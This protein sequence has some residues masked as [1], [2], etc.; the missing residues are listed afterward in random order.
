MDKLAQ[1]SEQASNYYDFA[2]LDKLRSSTDK[3]ALEAAAKQF[4]SIFTKM[5]LTSMRKASEVLESDSPFNSQS[6]KFYRDMHDQQMVSNIANTGGLGLADMIMEQLAGTNEKFSPASVLRNDGG[7]PGQPNK[8]GSAMDV[9]VP[10]SKPLEIKSNQGQ[11]FDFGQRQSPF[12]LPAANY[13]A[14]PPSQ[15]AETHPANTAANTSTNTSTSKGE[16]TSGGI[17]EGI[18]SSKADKA[19]LFDSP[20]SFIESLL[21]HARKVA[22]AKGM[23]PLM[24]IAQAAL[25]TGWGKKVIKKSDGSSSHNLFGIKADS[26][27]QGDKAK[28]QTLEFKDGVAKKENAFF[29]A[30]NSVEESVKDYMNFVS[31]DD[32]YKEAM[33]NVKDP[34]KYFNALQSAG[35]ATDPNYANKVVNILNGKI[36]AKAVGNE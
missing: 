11:S 16:S 1:A 12:Q 36:F 6:T 3:S 13:N 28:V 9:I 30:Y 18:S 7:L 22:A 20:Q 14:Q 2:G 15:S 27:W 25:E 10:G 17:S 21:P 31:S 33:N 26:R 29:R 32:R 19:S 8:G 24:L 23:E 35:Y 4:E 5:L 34:S